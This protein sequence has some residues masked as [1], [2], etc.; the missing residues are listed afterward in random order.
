MHQHDRAAARG[1]QRKRGR[2]VRQRR[3][4]VDQRR[5]GVERTRHHGGLARIDRQRRA[6]Q[7]VEDR[8]DAPQLLALRDRFGARAGGLAAD[9]DDGCSRRDH[10]PRRRDGIA[11]CA[12]VAEAVGGDVQDTHY[13]W[14]GEGEAGDGDSGGS[15]AREGGSVV[16]AVEIAAF[17]TDDGWC[18]H[19]RSARPRRSARGRP[20]AVR[21]R[22]SCRGED[23][24]ETRHHSLLLPLL[25]WGGG[26]GE[27]SCRSTGI[28]GRS[29][30]QPPPQVGRGL[31]HSPPPYTPAA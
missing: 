20:R 18:R 7:C 17:A 5:T 12:T 26:R 8:S 3:D 30:P 1:D 25:T 11:M 13:R 19:A 28:A 14:T 23:S 29:L 10:R 27:G 15:E 4:I 2:I 6:R 31:R 24:G 16:D 22:R 21:R 9:I